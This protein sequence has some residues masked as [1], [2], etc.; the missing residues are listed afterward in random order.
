[1]VTDFTLELLELVFELLYEHPD[2]IVHDQ[3]VFF[4]SETSYDLARSAIDEVYNLN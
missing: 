1:V 3:R 2:L 4:V